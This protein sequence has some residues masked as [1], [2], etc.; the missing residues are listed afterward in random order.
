MGFDV[1]GNKAEDEV[2]GYFRNNVWWWRGLWRYCE[3]VGEDII[4][5][6][7]NGQYN[8]GWGLDAEAS[9]KL[10][11]VLQAEIDSGRCK[12]YEESYKAHL[13]AIPDEPCKYCDATGIRTDEVGV[14]DGLDK[15][16]V[17]TEGHPRFGEI[18][19]CNAC[20]GVGHSRPFATAYGFSVENTQEFATFLKNCG[21]F[22]IW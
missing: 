14:R 6:D 2:G 21:G 11:D 5:E 17:T 8:D 15:Q 16:P 4:P 18:G 3:Q 19:T 10:A 12:A 20:N 9:A 13:A 22:E 1:I 7:N